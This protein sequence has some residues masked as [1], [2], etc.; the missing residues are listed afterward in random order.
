MFGILTYSVLGA[1]RVKN[2]FV[3]APWYALS[4]Y[5]RR[6]VNRTG[7]HKP[8]RVL[9]IHTEFMLYSDRRAGLFSGLSHGTMSVIL[10]FNALSSVFSLGFWESNLG[11]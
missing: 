1:F 9:L 4:P 6:R 10:E 3:I 2:S 7:Y 5:E 8:F 11:E